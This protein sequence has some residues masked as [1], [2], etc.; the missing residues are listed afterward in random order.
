M[1]ASS[2]SALALA[3]R[4]RALDDHALSQLVTDR[5][6]RQQGIR[7]FFDL[8]EALL[9]RGNVQAALQRLDRPTLAL[10][11]VAGDLAQT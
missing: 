1:P 2:G 10:L 8:A 3:A 11:A 7:D 5:G 6:I 4:L 9:D